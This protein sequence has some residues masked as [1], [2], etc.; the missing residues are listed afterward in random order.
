[1]FLILY[2]G[3]SLSFKQLIIK[4]FA[5]QMYDLYHKRT[6]HTVVLPASTAKTLV[7]AKWRTTFAIIPLPNLQL[8]CHP[9]NTETMGL[10]S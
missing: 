5:N 1:M 4:V 7:V 3:G 8:T 10:V 9:K 6:L 2:I